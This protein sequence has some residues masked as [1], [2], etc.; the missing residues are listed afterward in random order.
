M[1]EKRDVFQD[2]TAEEIREKEDKVQAMDFSNREVWEL[3]KVALKTLL[4][5]VLFLLAGFGAFYFLFKLWLA[6]VS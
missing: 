4:P 2:L 6:S 1:F 3:Y 5:I